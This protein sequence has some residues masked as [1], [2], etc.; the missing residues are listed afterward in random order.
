MDSVSAGFSFFEVDVGNT[1]WTAVS[2]W[3]PDNVISCPACYLHVSNPSLSI[4]SAF[5]PSSQLPTTGD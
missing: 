1:S 2:V 4:S 5:G 3:Q